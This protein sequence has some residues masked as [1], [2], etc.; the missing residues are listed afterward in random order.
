MLEKVEIIKKD[1]TKINLDLI[2]EFRVQQG[3]N[4]KKFAL[5]TANE[6]DQNGLIKLLASEISGTQLIKIASD[7]DWTLVKNIMRSII[8]GSAKDFTYTNTSDNMSFSVDDDF[9]RIIAVQDAAK[10]ALTKDYESNKP[11]VEKQE[12]IPSQVS[13]DENNNIYPTESVVSPIGSEIVP[14]IAET[15]SVEVSDA[16]AIDEASNEEVGEIVENPVVEE[17]AVDEVPQENEVEESN[18]DDSVIET[19]PLEEAPAIGDAPVNEEVVEDNS[20][21]I[22]DEDDSAAIDSAREQLIQDI[23]AAV[24]KYLASLPKKSANNTK[25]LQEKISKMQED[26]NQLNEVIQTQE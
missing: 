7:E 13:S 23:M 6:I 20:N 12:N 5:L 1:G 8:S 24:D 15:P 18:M 17:T 21:I 11:Q 3:E 22:E 19:A 25:E 26:L 16:P 9:A 2:S 14:G 10:Q 4:F